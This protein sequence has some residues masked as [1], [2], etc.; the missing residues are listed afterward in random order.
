MISGSM[1]VGCHKRGVALGD[2]VIEDCPDNP[3]TSPPGE[4]LTD[5]F[6]PFQPG[7]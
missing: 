7:T 4:S 5:I 6:M 3:E 1:L 2:L